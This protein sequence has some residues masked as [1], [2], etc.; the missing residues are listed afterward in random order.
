MASIAATSLAAA[1]NLPQGTI[2]SQLS[3]KD[4][5]SGAPLNCVFSIAN[6]GLFVIAGGDHL[7]TNWDASDPE[8]LPPAGN[9]TVHVRAIDPSTGKQVAA[10]ALVIQILS[11]DLLTISLAPPDGATP[12]PTGGW[13]ITT[14]DG[15]QISVEPLADTQ[16]NSQQG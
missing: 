8:N 12:T 11:T 14:P 9:H 5:N 7:A 2:F 4:P 16:P 1:D 6:P 10:S 15:A 13:V 3:V